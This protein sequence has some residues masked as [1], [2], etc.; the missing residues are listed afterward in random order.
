MT[1]FEKS[2]EAGIFLRAFSYDVKL[3]SEGAL[4]PLFVI[5]GSF[6]ASHLYILT[7]IR[8]AVEKYV[9]V[10]LEVLFDSPGDQK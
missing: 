10:L 4:T 9:E 2:R 6:M 1:T 7:L 3:K 8:A 5:S